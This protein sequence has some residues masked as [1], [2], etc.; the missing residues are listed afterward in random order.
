MTARLPLVPLLAGALLAP[1][2]AAPPAS[3][4]PGIVQVDVLE[5]LGIPARGEAWITDLAGALDEGARG[6]LETLAARYQAGSGH[7]VAVLIL[8]SLQ[9]RPIEQVALEVFRT[10]ELGREGVDD[11]ALLLVALEDRELRIE[12]GRGLEGELT[13]L[14]CGRIIDHVIVP[15]LR[16]E[17]LAGGLSDGL[18]ALHAA[19]G[20]DYGAIPDRPPVDHVLPSI[21]PVVIVLVILF[22]ALRGRGRR[23]RSTAFPLALDLAWSLG[24]ALG[25]LRG[26]GGFPGSRGGFGGFGGS[27]RG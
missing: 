16:A 17:D 18:R 11:G 4:P 14:V 19:A 7:D 8:G 1:A 9:G 26:R 23:T 12:V 6:E 13:D 2:A 10:W 24:Q 15:H 21:L 27:S 25:G 3:V 22:L 5:R 20:G